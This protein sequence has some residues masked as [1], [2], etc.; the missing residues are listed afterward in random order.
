MQLSHSRDDDLSCI[1]VYLLVERRIFTLNTRNCVFKLRLVCFRF[2]LDRNVD[3]WLQELCTFQQDRMTLLA[4]RVSS[5]SHRQTDDCGNVP[6]LQ[7][8]NLCSLVR[9]KLDQ[10]ADALRFPSPRVEDSVSR[11]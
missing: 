3:H 6:G 5:D 1:R 11:N 10:G 2:R 8:I 4:N 9:M 7:T